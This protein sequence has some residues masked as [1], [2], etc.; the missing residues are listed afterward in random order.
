M[1]G[2]NARFGVE[3]L[4]LAGSPDPREADEHRRAARVVAGHAVDLDDCIELLGMLGISTGQNRE[5]PPVP[6]KG[7]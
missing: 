7:A 2:R 6:T 1:H 3:A 5:G 4:A